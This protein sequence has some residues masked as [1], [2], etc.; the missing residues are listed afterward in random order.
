MC[1]DLEHQFTVYTLHICIRVLVEPKEL[2]GL[3]FPLSECW[4]HSSA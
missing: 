4:D 3:Y 2:Y 1:T